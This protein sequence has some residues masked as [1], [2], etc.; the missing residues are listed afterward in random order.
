MPKE[1]FKSVTIKAYVL[2]RAERYFED[3]KA[4]FRKKGI[5]SSSALCSFCIEHVEM[6]VKA[7]DLLRK[8]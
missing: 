6:L 4:E 3:H 8:A 5:K 1:G 7:S 2:D